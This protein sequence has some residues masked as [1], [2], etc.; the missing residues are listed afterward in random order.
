MSY[1]IDFKKVTLDQYKKELLKR[2]LIPSR[3]LLKDKADIHFDA[4]NKASIKT[5]ADL[6]SIKYIQ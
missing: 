2:T 5:L 3:Q 6:F 1:S 4:F